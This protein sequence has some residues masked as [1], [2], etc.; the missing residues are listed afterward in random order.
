MKN[1]WVHFFESVLNELSDRPGASGYQ[2]AFLPGKPLK[3]GEGVY[4]AYEN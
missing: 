3:W 2:R 1:F 4:C